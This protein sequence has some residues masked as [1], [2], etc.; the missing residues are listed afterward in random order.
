MKKIFAILLVFL[1]FASCKKLSD[2]NKNIKDPTTT[3]GESLFTGAQKAFFDQMTTS[4]VNLNIW[5][6]MDQYWNETTYDD[7]SNYN[8]V[9]R[10]IPD[11]HWNIIYTSVLKNLNQSTKIITST[12]YPDD[13]SP[14]IKQ[15]KLAIIDVLAVHAWSTLVETFGDIPYSQALDI[16]NVLPKYDDGKTVYE[17]LIKRLN[18]DITTLENNFTAYPAGV[19]FASADNVYGSNAEG[20]LTCWIKYANS[21]RLRMGMLLADCDQSF[22]VTTVNAS[23]S[24]LTKLI[25][26]NS[27]NCVLN[28]LGSA[29]NTN[30]MYEDQ[31]ASGRHDFVA[32]VTVIDTM[33]NWNDPR[34]PL[35]FTTV[36]TGASNTPAYIGAQVGLNGFYLD[37]SNGAPIM[38]TPTFPGTMF[39]Y[40]EVE[41]LLAEACARGGYSVGGTAAIHYAN[42]ITASIEYWGG[43]AAQA[44]TYLAQPQVVYNSANWK[45][46]IGMQQWLAYYNRGFDGWT[47]LRKMQYPVLQPGVNALSAFPVRFTYPIEEQTLN[48]A[49]YSAASAAIGGDAVTTTLFFWKSLPA[50]TSTRTKRR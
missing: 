44:T 37:F 20:D 18:T 39:E 46:S 34:L 19:G 21:L 16:T 5:R 30:P 17:A 25:Q 35:Y 42:A 31:V 11:N 33:V 6:L 40:S 32:A 36:D 14:T 38:W 13:P 49:N 8:L 22:S 1:V 43:T 26:S 28:Y 7:E 45:E 2:L 41:F 47:E 15:N 27:E 4:N 3:T 24:D 29:P 12:S 50:Y 10:S 48:G 9:E 23:A